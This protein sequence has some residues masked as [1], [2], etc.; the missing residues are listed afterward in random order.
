MGKR[1]GLDTAPLIF[2]IEEYE[3]Y[4]SVLAPFFTELE[5]GKFRVV[6]S[7]VTLLE[8]LVHPLR[9]RNEALAA[10]YNDILLSSSAISTLPVTFATAQEAAELRS[11]YNLKTPD[12]IQLATAMKEGATTFL[13]NDRDFPDVPGVAI[14]RVRDLTD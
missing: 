9:Q 2:F 1:V 6:T 13:T 3:K 5:L 4:I 8:V 14:L 11:H 12:A 7:V 10:Q